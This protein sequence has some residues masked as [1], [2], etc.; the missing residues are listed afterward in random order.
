MKIKTRIPP[1]VYALATAGVMWLVA[2][3]APAA[4]VI[5]MP[6]NNVG[7]GLI[8]MGLG[9]DLYSVILFIRTRTTVNPMQVH[10]ANRLIVTGL[11]RISRNP[12]YLGLVLALS[13]WGVLLG[14]PLTLL[15]VWALAR[16]LVVVQITPEE[17]ALRER[18]GEAY[19]RYSRR[20][21]RW[22]GRVNPSK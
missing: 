3:F 13:G 7:W 21:N 17:E 2:R 12:M 14:N 4:R 19:L 9:I 5:V 1:P 15:F 16:T 10:R 11:Y 18:F 8:A 20:V 6:W 22:F